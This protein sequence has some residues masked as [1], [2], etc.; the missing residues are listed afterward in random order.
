MGDRILVGLTGKAGVGK[1]TAANLFWTHH[2]L[3]PYALAGPIKAALEAMGF[4]REQYD[5]DG[6]KDEVI[7]ELGVSYRQLAQTLGTEWGRQQHPA[8]WLVLAKRFFERFAYMSGMVISD[9]RF[10]NEATWVRDNGGTVIHVRGPA[11]RS[12]AAGREGHASEAGV[13]AKPGDLILYNTATPQ[14]LK[15]Q[16]DTLMEVMRANG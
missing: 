10:E 14:F 7:L 2:S 13:E 6:A 9:V 12:I 11:R 8:F 3:Q 16:I 4:S 1:D 5:K 15:E